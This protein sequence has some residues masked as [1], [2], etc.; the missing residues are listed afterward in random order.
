MAH[1][2]TRIQL[3]DEALLAHGCMVNGIAWMS[4][5]CYGIKREGEGEVGGEG[6]EGG[7]TDDQS[8]IAS[9]H[10]AA[11]IAWVSTF[12][13]DSGNRGSGWGGRAMGKEVVEGRD[14]EG[15]RG[16]CAGEEC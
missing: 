8:C 13:V 16:G 11:D 9:H 15:G 3:F 10:T 6:G 2:P 4:G 5:L 12:T 7:S 1:Y 14:K